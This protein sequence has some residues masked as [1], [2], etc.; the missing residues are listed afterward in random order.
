MPTSWRTFRCCTLLAHVNNSSALLYVT[1]EFHLRDLTSDVS[2]LS[3]WQLQ[4]EE[5][6]VIQQNDE[7]P[8]NTCGKV[9]TWQEN[10]QSLALPTAAG[11]FLSIYLSRTR[12]FSSALC[13]SQANILSRDAII[14][15]LVP[16]NTLVPSLPSCPGGALLPASNV[17]HRGT[18]LMP[19]SLPDEKERELSVSAHWNYSYS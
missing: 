4:I 18:L 16:G 8:L 5:S 11:N 3:N 14:I 10:V 13:Q 2:I 12:K 17:R 1:Q 7:Q 9:Y 15:S 19:L 6:E